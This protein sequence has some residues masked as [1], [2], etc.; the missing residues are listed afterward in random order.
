[1]DPRGKQNKMTKVIFVSMGAKQTHYF[2]IIII[3]IIITILLLVQW[4]FTVSFQI[5]TVVQDKLCII[6][7]LHDF[8]TKIKMVT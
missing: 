5:F 1:M 8:N 3:I 6:S 4:L 7:T 2:Y